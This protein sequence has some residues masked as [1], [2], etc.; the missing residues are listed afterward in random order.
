M[1]FST[2]GET[3]NCTNCPGQ[4][5]SPCA[6]HTDIFMA[7]FFLFLVTSTVFRCN[8]APSSGPCSAWFCTWGNCVSQE[9]VA[10]VC[11]HPLLYSDALLTHWAL[12]MSSVPSCPTHIVLPDILAVTK[13]ILLQKE[14]SPRSAFPQPGIS[15]GLNARGGDRKIRWMGMKGRVRGVAAPRAR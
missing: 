5:G 15:P 12:G 3:R 7:E 11:S 1:V 13:G 8:R 14:F 10:V 2:W 4:P 9:H 6:G